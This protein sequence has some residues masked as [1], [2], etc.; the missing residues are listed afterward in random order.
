MGGIREAMV[1]PIVPP[2]VMELGNASGFSAYLTAA[3]G[4]SHGRGVV[5]PWL[6]YRGELLR[7][8]APRSLPGSLNRADEFE[9]TGVGLANV[10]RIVTRHGGTVFAQGTLGGGATFGFTLPRRA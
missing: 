5:L 3:A 2:A 10:R 8:D 1:I 6:I 7:S 9:G 4:Q